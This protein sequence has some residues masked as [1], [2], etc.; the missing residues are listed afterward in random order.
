MDQILLFAC[1]IEIAVLGRIMVDVAHDKLQRYRAKVP[2]NPR[3]DNT[4]TPVA[5]AVLA[6]FIREADHCRK[7]AAARAEN[8]KNLERIF[9]DGFAP[10]T[11]AINKLR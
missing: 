4:K 1:I 6:E 8:E 3:E 7:L 11:D 9:R 10:L 2:Q 5:E